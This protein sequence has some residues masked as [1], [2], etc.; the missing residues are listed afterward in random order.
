[1]DKEQLNEVLEAT[2]KGF[3][4]MVEREHPG[5]DEKTKSMYW[6]LQRKFL[7]YLSLWPYDIEDDMPEITVTDNPFFT[8]KRNNKQK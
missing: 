6:L 7:K 4:E 8:L 5:L 2:K 1:M 3:Y